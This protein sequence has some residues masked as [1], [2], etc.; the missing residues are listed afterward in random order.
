MLLIIDALLLGWL[1]NQIQFYLVEEKALQYIH[2]LREYE[3]QA[4]DYYEYT[5]IFRNRY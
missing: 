5:E 2:K 4:T 1:A 3:N